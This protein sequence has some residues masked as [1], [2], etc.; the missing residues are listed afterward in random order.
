MQSFL[1]IL[2]TLLALIYLGRS[3]Y[4]RFFTETEKCEGC[5]MGKSSQVH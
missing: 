1:V 4:K 5:A 2:V 3:V